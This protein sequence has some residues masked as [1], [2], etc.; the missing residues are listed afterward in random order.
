MLGITA[1]PLLGHFL[2]KQGDDLQSGGYDGALFRFYSAVLRA[3]IKLRWIVIAALIATTAVCFVMF[4][5]INQ[6]FFPDCNTPLYFVHY[7]LPQG[8]SIHQTSEDMQ[9]LESWL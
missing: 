1:T 6:Q 3:C 5:S 4:G 2:F 8:A 7:K 9:V